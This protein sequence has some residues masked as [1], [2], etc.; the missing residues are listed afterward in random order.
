M[1][2]SSFEIAVVANF[3]IPYSLVKWP[4]DYFAKNMCK[5]FW[6]DGKDATESS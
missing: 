2:H 1:L 6:K 3:T 4:D 5:T